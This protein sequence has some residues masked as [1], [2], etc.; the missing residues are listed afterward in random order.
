LSDLPIF[1]N[2]ETSSTIE[3]IIS[4]YM[5]EGYSLTGLEI[6]LDSIMHPRVSDLEISLTHHDVT[7]KLVYHVTDQ[8]SNFLWTKLTDDASKIVTDGIAPFS[9]DHKPY[10]PLAAFNGMDPNGDWTLTIYDSETGHEG[11]L[12][13]WGIKPFYE[14]ATSIDD[15][16]IYAID[17]SILLSQNFPNPFQGRTSISWNSK[18]GG[19]T[20]LKV[21]NVNGQQVADLVHRF[22][23]AGEHAV[24][25]DGSG[26]SPGLYYYQLTV[27]G[28]VQT[29]KMILYR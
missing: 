6:Y 23:P 11:T 24:T 14:K 1:D 18:L 16:G 28:L 8:G 19:Q 2:Q 10:Q 27:N 26:L 25:F 17:Q 15:E 9:G 4:D 5:K 21:F 3:V 12:N 29:Q 22:M 20:L 13:A 7:E